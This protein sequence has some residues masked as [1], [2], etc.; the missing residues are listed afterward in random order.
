MGFRV[1]NEQLAEELAGFWLPTRRLYIKVSVSS[2]PPLNSGPPSSTCPR[3]DAD[4][5]RS[6]TQNMLA[7]IKLRSNS[8]QIPSGTPFRRTSERQSEKPGCRQSIAPPSRSTRSTSFGEYEVN[9]VN[10][11]GLEALE[12]T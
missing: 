1:A 7:R 4:S 2:D 3:Q 12:T 9:K 8:G 11:V 6:L 10:K 5:A